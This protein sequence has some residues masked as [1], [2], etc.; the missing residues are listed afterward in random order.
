MQQETQVR[1][2]PTPEQQRLLDRIQVQRQRLVFLGTQRHPRRSLGQRLGSQQGS[3][4]LGM[5][6]GAFV[7]Q[8][9]LAL[10]AVAGAVWAIGPRRLARWADVVLPL[11]IKLRT[12]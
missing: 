5:R 9:P 10:V 4:P 12:Y 8:Y 7:R 3:F 11:L 2:I 1:I 6:M